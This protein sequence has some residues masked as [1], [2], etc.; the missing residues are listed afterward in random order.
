MSITKSKKPNTIIFQIF[1]DIDRILRI[2][3]VLVQLFDV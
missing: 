1:I 2:V 3:A